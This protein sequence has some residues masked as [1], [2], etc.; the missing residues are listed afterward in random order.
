MGDHRRSLHGQRPRRQSPARVN[1]VAGTT[2]WKSGG[3]RVAVKQ[4][5]VHPAWNS[6]N[7]DNDVALLHLSRRLTLSTAPGGSMRAIALV[8]AGTTFAENIPIPLTVTG[9][10]STVEGGS[11]SDTLRAA[12][13]PTVSN[14][15][16]NASESYGGRVTDNMFCAGNREGGVNSCQGDSGGPIWTTMGGKDTLLGVVSFGD[17]CAE[18]LKYGVYTRLANFTAWVQ[19]TMRQPREESLPSAWPQTKALCALPV[20]RPRPPGPWPLTNLT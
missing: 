14:R 19:R 2:Q 9:W 16:C 1:I 13:V 17:G 18:K 15:I 20:A 7:M 6:A 4:I 12:A 3:E 5:F 11:G 8:A 10:G